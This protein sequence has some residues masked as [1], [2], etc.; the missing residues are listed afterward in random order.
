MAIVSVRMAE[1]AGDFEVARALC[2]EWL[3]WHWQNYPSDWPT[4]ADHPMERQN[5]EAV[6][7]DLPMLHQRPRGAVLIGTVN[8]QDAGCVMYHKSEAGVAEFKRMF[9]SERGRGHGL[10]RKM[11]EDMFQRMIVDGY[12]KVFF[13]SATFLTHAR[14]MYESAGFT[15]IPHPPGFPDEWRDRVYFMHRTLV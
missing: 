2:R 9:V 4:G 14:A 1:N 5:F 11:L 6:L 15:G 12:E 13:S 3:D 10:G 7:R 8:G